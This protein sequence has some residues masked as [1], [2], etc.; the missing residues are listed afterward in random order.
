MTGRWGEFWHAQWLARGVPSD[1]EDGIV[2]DVTYVFDQWMD[3]F[4][5]VVDANDFLVGI[6]PSNYSD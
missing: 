5:G 6:Y 3:I 1:P 4:E 2:K